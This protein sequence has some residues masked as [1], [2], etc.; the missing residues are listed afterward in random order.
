MPQ[1][2]EGDQEGDDGNQ[3]EGAEARIEIILKKN[4]TIQHCQLAMWVSFGPEVQDAEDDRGDPEECRYG[5]EGEVVHDDAGEVD[6]LGEG[7]DVLR[8]HADDVEV[9]GGLRKGR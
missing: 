8:V 9:D 6:T 5:E 1:D 7:R 4:K 3:A 2:D